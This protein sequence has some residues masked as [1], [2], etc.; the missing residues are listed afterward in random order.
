MSKQSY[1]LND[2]RKKVLDSWERVFDF[3][4]KVD[5]NWC[6]KKE[7]ISIQATMWKVKWKQGI[8]VKEFIAR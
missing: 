1:I 4:R 3:N 8:S 6:G 2:F 5:E 7:N